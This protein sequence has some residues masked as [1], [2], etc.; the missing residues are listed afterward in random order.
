MSGITSVLPLP[1][2]FAT[3]YS[4]VY[5]RYDEDGWCRGIIS[6]DQHT[7]KIGGTFYAFDAKLDEFVEATAE[8]T[9]FLAR[10]T[11]SVLVRVAQS[12]V[13]YLV[14]DGTMT[15]ETLITMLNALLFR[16]GRPR[17]PPVHEDDA[18]HMLYDAAKMCDQ[19]VLVLTTV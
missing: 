16:S 18:L 6:E 3:P 10:H 12:Q 14:S 11:G 8:T 15:L 13:D 5:V 17:L 1:R 2:S 7:I 9:A 4:S 19:G